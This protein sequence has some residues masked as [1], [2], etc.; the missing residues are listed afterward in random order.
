MIFDP[1]SQQFAT[2]TYADG[3]W[4]PQMPI[5]NVGQSAWVYVNPYACCTNGCI[6][7]L[8]VSNLVEY[9]CSN[10]VPVYYP[11]TATNLCCTNGPVTLTF[12]PTNGTCFYPG[13]TNTVMCIGTDACGNCNSTNFTVTVLCESNNPCGCNGSNGVTV[14]AQSFATIYNFTNGYDGANPMAGLILSSNILYGTTQNG[15]DGAYGHGTVFALNTNG[16]GFMD[17]HVFTYG[18]DGA[19]PD[20]VL[21]LSGNT[22]Y[23]TAVGGGVGTN[24]WGT[25]FAV[26]INDSSFTTLHTFAGDSDGAL[27]YGGLL[28]SG[29]NLFGRQQGESMKAMETSSPSTPMARFIPACM[30]SPALPTTDKVRLADWFYW[31]IPFMGRQIAQALTTKARCS[32]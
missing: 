10:C 19:I 2:Y 7:F 5:L 24:A 31:A 6:Q 12:D 9:S 18:S 11:L 26:N 28:L 23:G 32:L 16:T 30:H 29:S 27:P 1:I 25:V 4:N 8:N 3:A 17:L 14:A 13:T 21:I 20:G 22:L 15:G